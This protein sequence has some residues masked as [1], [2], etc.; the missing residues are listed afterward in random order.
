M[1]PVLRIKVAQFREVDELVSRLQ[2]DFLRLLFSESREKI[3]Y[4]EIAE[5]LKE[6]KETRSIAPMAEMRPELRDKLARWSEVAR[7]AAKLLG[8]AWVLVREEEDSPEKAHVIHVLTTRQKRLG[9]KKE[10]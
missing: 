3:K 2:T 4:G 1:N 6:M 10:I 8:E 9:K 5:K 7:R